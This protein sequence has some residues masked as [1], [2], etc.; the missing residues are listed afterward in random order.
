[1]R[2][3]TKSSPRISLRDYNYENARIITR[4]RETNCAS[5]TVATQ[6]RQVT[7]QA[8]VGLLYKVTQAQNRKKNGESFFYI[9]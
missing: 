2:V 1:M 4:K 5:A 3:T 6:A 9:G 7:T 8:R